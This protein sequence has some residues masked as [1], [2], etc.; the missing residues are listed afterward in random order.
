MQN[1]FL[2]Y[3]LNQETLKEERIMSLVIP[4]ECQISDEEIE[5][6]RKLLIKS[7]EESKVQIL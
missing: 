4:W 5:E 1:T 6:I 7:I 2:I 3:K